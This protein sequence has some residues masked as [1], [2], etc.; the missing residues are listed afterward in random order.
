M[1]FILIIEFWWAG[2]DATFD[3]VSKN[4]VHGVQSPLKIFQKPCPP[5]N[6]LREGWFL[7]SGARSDSRRRLRLSHP[8]LQKE[9]MFKQ[10]G[11]SLENLLASGIAGLDLALNQQRLDR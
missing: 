10:E 11:T 2:W 5:S 6:G 4:Y 7:A 8:E 1:K 9:R 3:K